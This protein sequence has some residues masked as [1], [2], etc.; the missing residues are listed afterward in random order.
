[1][2]IEKATAYD[3]DLLIGFR[4]DFLKE[5]FPELTIEEEKKI[6]CQLKEYLPKRL[7]TGDFVAYIAFVDNNVASTVFMTIHEM[8]A[9]T[10]APAGKIGTI[11][12]VYTYPQYR[13]NGYASKT[14]YQ[15]IEEAKKKG[16]SSLN[17]NATDMGKSL[18]EK[19]GFKDIPY[20]A[21]YLK[22]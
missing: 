13:K 15:I 5:E 11:L 2:R 8:P 6:V 16:I 7:N 17:L 12:N 21:M 10:S 14:M 1:M 20:S 4:L 22:L 18:Y 19:V 3:I 9:N